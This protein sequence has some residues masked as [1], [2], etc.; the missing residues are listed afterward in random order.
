MNFK[1]KKILILI[2]AI[3]LICSCNNSS[4]TE[5]VPIKKYLEGIDDYKNLFLV[6]NDGRYGEFGGNSYEI[7]IYKKRN[8][9]RLFADYREY[10]ATTDPP[11]PPDRNDYN[12]IMRPLYLRFPV[13]DSTIEIKIN[14]FQKEL[15]E[16]A[17]F[18]LIN[19]Q[20]NV[21]NAIPGFYGESYF[22]YTS[23][24]TLRIS[25]GKPNNWKN[26]KLL[27]QSL[28]KKNK[29]EYQVISKR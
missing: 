22:V 3:F 9:P 7:K 24:Y 8:D 29:R 12:S 17:V 14:E 20:L 21:E 28:L 25:D 4:E 10:E 16:K 18:E 23:N 6:F 19:N 5:S 1:I 27:K 13:I 15:A 26:Y 11:P 2:S